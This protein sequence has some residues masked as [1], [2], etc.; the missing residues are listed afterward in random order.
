MLWSFHTG[1]L[2]AGPGLGSGVG[3]GDRQPLG[4]AQCNQALEELVIVR[5]ACL[6]CLI[7]CMSYQADTY[8]CD[9]CFITHTE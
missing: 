7:I 9:L 1:A 2:Q 4:E 3:G 6:L 5:G 8:T